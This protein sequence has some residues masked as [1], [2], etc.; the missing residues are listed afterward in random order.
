MMPFLPRDKRIQCSL[1]VWL[2]IQEKSSQQLLPGRVAATMINISKS[3]ACLI[4]PNMFIA[5]E[6][7][8]FTTLNGSHSLL[9]Q[10]QESG[11]QLNKFL[12]SA[13][14][15]WMDSREYLDQLTFML[16]ICYTTTQKDLFD[17]IKHLKGK[18]PTNL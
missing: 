12:I 16:G 18:K 4:V 3:G 7:L 13:R 11:K 8:F 2:S 1:P 9:L 14:S 6:H 10:P 15:V 5:G 17:N